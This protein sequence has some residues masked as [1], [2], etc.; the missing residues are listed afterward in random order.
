MMID[1]V[2]RKYFD[3]EY[4][5]G[6]KIAASGKLNEE[7]FR[8][9]I[10][11]DEFIDQKPPKSTGREYYGE[12]FLN[13]VLDD[14]Q[15]DKKDLLATVTEFTAYAVFR[16]IQIFIKEFPDELYISGGGALNKYLVKVLSRYIGKGNKNKES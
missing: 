15:I 9:M 11:A 4:D 6:G 2:C 3:V 16:N 5:K 7:V 1:L 14:I 10:E 12:V 8:K 13:R